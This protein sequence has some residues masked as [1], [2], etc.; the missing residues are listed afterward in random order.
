VPLYIGKS[1]NLRS[2]VLSHLRNGDEASLLRQTRRISH[3]CT[4][5]GS[6]RSCSKRA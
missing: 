2:R 3:I 1:V 4:I 6:A 5:G